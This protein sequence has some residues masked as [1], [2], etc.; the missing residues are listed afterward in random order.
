MADPRIR[1]EIL[2]TAEKAALESKAPA[3]LGEKINLGNRLTHEEYVDYY[4]EM[5]DKNYE[6][7]VTFKRPGVMETMKIGGM[8]SEILREAGVRDIRLVDTSA[9]YY[10]GILATMQVVVTKAP[11]WL[12]KDLKTFNDFDLLAHLF[13]LYETWL[14]SFRKPTD[15]ETATDGS[16]D[17][18]GTEK[19]LDDA[20]NIP[21]PGGSPPAV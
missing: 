6:G 18:P 17:T 14:D 7:Y 9:H 3:V 8:K 5:L 12:P 10:A 21:G 2:R 16:G 4:S 1:E 15:D 11:S 13:L 20:K 19:A